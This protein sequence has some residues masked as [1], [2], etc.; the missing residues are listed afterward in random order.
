MKLRSPC[1]LSLFS[2]SKVHWRGFFSFLCGALVS[3]AIAQH[4]PFQLNQNWRLPSLP[5]DQWRYLGT[6]QAEGNQWFFYHGLAD[7]GQLRAFA[8]DRQYY[9]LSDS[10]SLSLPPAAREAN[11][12]AVHPQYFFSLAFDRLVVHDRQSGRAKT[13]QLPRPFTEISRQGEWLFLISSYDFAGDSALAVFRAAIDRPMD[14]LHLD[15]LLFRSTW[16]GRQMS[17]VMHQWVVLSSDR[18]LTVDP[19]GQKVLVHD[20]EGGLL[21]ELSLPLTNDRLAVTRRLDEIYR[22]YKLSERKAMFLEMQEYLQ[23]V[24]YLEK[25]FYGDGQLWLSVKPAAPRA[26]QRV[27]YRWGR[28]PDGE[29]LPQYH[30]VDTLDFQSIS[31]GDDRYRYRQFPLHLELNRAVHFKAEEVFTALEMS[32]FPREEL[33]PAAYHQGLEEYLQKGRICHTILRYAIVDP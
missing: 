25:I 27:L 32:Y 3:Q 30:G 24:S 11:A 8:V 20:Q 16:P 6:S 4:A 1:S 15:T 28:H 19:I 2:G 13:H 31:S 18:L 21:Q 29:F 22:R 14:T 23:Q 10:V 12:A 26:D 9:Q 5:Y 7:P 33:S 17:M